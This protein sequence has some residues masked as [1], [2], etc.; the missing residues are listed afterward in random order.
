MSS[1]DISDWDEG[2]GYVTHERRCKEKWCWPSLWKE[3]IT[4]PMGEYH[5]S[6]TKGTSEQGSSRLLFNVR[7]ACLTQMLDDA[8]QSYCLTPT[9]LAASTALLQS[10]RNYLSRLLPQFEQ[11]GS[12]NFICSF[13]SD[14]QTYSCPNSPLSCDHM[15]LTSKPN[16]STGTLL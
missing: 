9:N 10:P 7:V 5:L 1:Q 15:N 2:H 8:T 11:T 3:C 13:H 6:P 14:Q 4:R 12:R 16:S